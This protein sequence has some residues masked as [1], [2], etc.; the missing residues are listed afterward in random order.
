MSLTNREIVDFY[1]NNGLI[2]TC[3]ECQFANLKDRSKNDYKEDFFQDL[4]VI[5]LTYDNEKLNDAHLN[6]HF[7]A[8]VTA[9][10]IRQLFSK[11]SPFYKTYIKFADR[12]GEITE[13]L[14]DTLPD[15]ESPQTDYD[16]DDIQDDDEMLRI[17][18]AVAK[19][20]TIQ[21]TI[22]KDYCELGSYAALARKLKVSKPTARSYIRQIKDKIYNNL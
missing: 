8:L 11:T 22:F 3:V 17:K 6:N 21:R 19:L 9:I 7:N 20:N 14:E 18:E 5:L 12:T 1:L 2:R 16:P 13:V 10:C 15:E 4:I